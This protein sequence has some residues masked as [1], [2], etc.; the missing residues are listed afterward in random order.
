MQV[1][2]CICGSRETGFGCVSAA[3]SRKHLLGIR[4]NNNSGE[5]S[6]VE[7]TIREGGSGVDQGERRVV[8]RAPGRGS[9]VQQ[10][11]RKVQAICV[12]HEHG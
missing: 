4:C 6:G 5:S 12:D 2:V 11:V 1:E 8:Q 7:W 3:D 10:W 9:K